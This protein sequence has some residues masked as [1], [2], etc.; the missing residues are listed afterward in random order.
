MA[1]EIANFWTGICVVGAFALLLV[2]L[3]VVGWRIL[4]KQ[5]TR[6]GLVVFCLGAGIATVEAQKRLYV[7][8]TKETGDPVPEE[9]IEQYGCEHTFKTIG[10]A[11]DFLRFKAFSDVDIYV[12][13]GVYPPVEEPNIE[14]CPYPIPVQMVPYF[15]VSAIGEPGSVIIDGGG[16]EFAIKPSGQ[17]ACPRDWHGFVVSNAVY[18]TVGGSYARCI[19]TC[20][21]VG[22]LNS[23]LFHSIATRNTGV[24]ALNCNL[25]HCLVVDNHAQSNENAAYDYAGVQNCSLFGTIV[26]N[27]TK[28]GLLANGSEPPFDPTGVT[29]DS[30][31]VD[32][33]HGNYRPRMGSP[34]IN[35]DGYSAFSYIEFDDDPRY[36]WSLSFDDVTD[37]FDGNPRCQ[38]GLVD[39]G[40]WE[41]QPTNE[42]QTITAPEPVEFAWIEEKCPEVLKECGGDHDKAVLMKS[43]NPVDISLPEPL[44]TY[45]SIWESY[46]ADLDPTDSNQTFR[47][48]IEMADGEPIVKGD[49]ES[50]NRKYTILG[51]EKLS[52]ESWQENLPGAR[53]FKVKVGLK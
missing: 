9:I 36:M 47:A 20:C 12:A 51:K 11:F 21:Q 52:D 38:R 37:D 13:P 3:F 41:Y 22:F 44:R 28:D 18:G 17:T 40:P 16:G 15:D 1:A 6:M 30:L 8:I 31:F 10:E 53:F 24:G 14:P 32:A 29:A 46:V 26:W 34:Y 43:A 39:Y 48:T 19:A 7:D 42:H 23:R 50:P 33:A 45:Y 27:N 25:N 49:P 5:L 4:G 35:R 2:I